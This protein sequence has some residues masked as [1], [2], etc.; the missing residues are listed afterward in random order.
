MVGRYGALDGA[1][2]ARGVL[3]FALGM[4]LGLGEE[5]TQLLAYLGVRSGEGGRNLD[6]MQQFP[7]LV[8]PTNLQRILRINSA[9]DYSIS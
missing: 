5:L 3:V 7:I 9:A 8:P 4:E 2:A 1:D 6:S